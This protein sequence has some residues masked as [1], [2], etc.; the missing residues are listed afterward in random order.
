[1]VRKQYK[2]YDQLLL[3]VKVFLLN[4]VLISGIA[5]AQSLSDNISQDSLN[6]TAPIMGSSLYLDVTLNGNPIG[7]LHLGYADGKI[8]GNASTLRQLGFKLPEEITQPVCLNDIPRLTV[9]YNAQQQTLALTAP[10]DSLDLSTIQINQPLE[11]RPETTSSRGAL[12][13]YDLY[14][15]QGKET[16]VNTFSELRAFSSAGVLSSTQL[17][18]YSTGQSEY[19]RF[20]RLDT[21]WRTSFADKMVAVTVGDTLTAPLSWTRSTRI[22]GIQVGTDFSLNPSMATTP[23][24]AFFGSATLPSSVELYVNGIKSYTGDVPAGNFQLNT[25]PNISGVGTAQVMMTDALGRTTTQDFSFYNDQLLL[26]EGLT[27]WSAELGVVREN[28]G[29]SSFDYASSP[30]ISGTW[31]RG[32]SNTLTSSLHM[33]TSNSLVNGG[34]GN[35][36][37]LFRQS[38]TISSA[39]SGSSDAGKSGLQYSIGYRWLGD[40]F[41]FSTST[42]F[43]SGNYRDVAT[44]YGQAPMTLNSS[45]VMGYSLGTAGNISLSYLQ[46]HYPDEQPARYAN[47]SWSRSLSGNLSLYTSF[48]QNTN[49]RR[50]SSIFLMLAVNTSNNF[51]AS[52]TIQRT[53]DKMS[54]QVNANRMAEADGGWSWNLAAG[55]QASQQS[56]QGSVGYQGR[57][58]KAYSGFSSTQGN[59]YGYAGATGSLVMMEGGLFA[60]QQINNSFAVISTDGIPDV[61]INVQNNLVGTSNSKGLLLVTHL[62]SYQKNHISIDPMGLPASMRISRIQANV[63]PEDRAGALVKFEITPVRSALVILVDSHGKV[64]PNGSSAMLMTGERQSA[65]VGFDGMVYFDTLEPQ[66]RLR[67]S[68]DTGTCFV[69]FPYPETGNTTQIGPLVCQ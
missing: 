19:N 68:T 18:T 53:N 54:Y 36:W 5:A 56:G 50:D 28:Y 6:D 29:Y 7:L 33:E 61:P 22:A 11:D 30:V 21:S 67:V 35:D 27:S 42:S 63:T 1:M 12:L 64:I 43:T 52:S 55:Q 17:M 45:T 14:T 2:I 65:A 51:S 4:S 24:P 40:K 3:L 20:D 57:Y 41:N 38:G 60:A 62:N 31:R 69:Q 8:Y 15:E 16:R 48:N 23:L 26:R 44:H 58:G 66:N 9:D 34:F 47:V 32:I 25:V 49:N 59:Q 46:F 10:L 37:V 39:L 13:N